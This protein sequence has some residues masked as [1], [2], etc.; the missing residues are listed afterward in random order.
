MLMLST[1]DRVWIKDLQRYIYQGEG[2]DKK[3]QRRNLASSLHLSVSFPFLYYIP[4]LT[5]GQARPKYF[6]GVQLNHSWSCSC[7]SSFSNAYLALPFYIC[8][9]LKILQEYIVED[10]HGD[11]APPKLDPEH[12]ERLKMLKL[13]QGGLE[14]EK[15]MS[16]TCRIIFSDMR[17]DC[18]HNRS[19]V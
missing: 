18:I 14:G 15:M 13:L 7:L 10:L 1:L 3:N 5:V 11:Y 2:I 19:L 12:E 8:A 16:K 17:T 6:G 9:S 4:P